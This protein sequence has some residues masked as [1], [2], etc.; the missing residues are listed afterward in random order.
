MRHRIL[1]SRRT[2]PAPDSAVGGLVERLNQLAHERGPGSKLPTVQEMRRDYNVSVTTVQEA[3]HTLEAGNVLYRRQGSGIYVSPHLHRK[4][5]RV[6]LNGAFAVGQGVSPFWGM[7]WGRTIEAAQKRAETQDETLDFHLVA[8]GA[9]IDD[10]YFAALESDVLTGRVHG[11]LSIGLDNAVPDWIRQPETPHVAYAG[12]GHWRVLSGDDSRIG[13]GIAALAEQGCRRIDYWNHIILALSGDLAQ[14]EKEAYQDALHAL[15]LP[16]PPGALPHLAEAIA[17]PEWRRLSIQEQGY[18]LTHHLFAGRRPPIDGLFIGDDMMTSGAIIAFHELGIQIG[19]DITLATGSNAGSP[20]LFGY[21][22]RLTRI[23]ID[24]G[25]IARA[26]FAMLDG[27]MSGRAPES[28]DAIVNPLIRL[29]DG[30]TLTV[31][32]TTETAS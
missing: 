1:P 24:P 30:R 23:E 10:A 6:L 14:K 18:R 32:G 16:V 28:P 17:T 25:A 7:L 4:N 21:E 31:N 19:R 29:P 3:L 11:L 22:K 20:I 2:N 5:V 13:V 8:L 15:Y 12:D 27:L 26:M 9:G